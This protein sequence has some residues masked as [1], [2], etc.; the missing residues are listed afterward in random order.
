MP[1]FFQKQWGQIPVATN[2]DYEN[3]KAKTE[4]KIK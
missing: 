3:F 2:K 4:K 1:P